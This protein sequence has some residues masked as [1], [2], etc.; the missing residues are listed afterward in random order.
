MDKIRFATDIATFEKAVGLYEGGKITQFKEELNGF[1]AVVLGTKPYKFTLAICV[2]M[3]EI[4]RVTL[5]KTM[6]YV[7]TWWQW[8]FGQL[9]AVC[10]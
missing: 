3:R 1:F 6:F 2:M 8:Q 10:H 4:A 5:A 9:R 7:N